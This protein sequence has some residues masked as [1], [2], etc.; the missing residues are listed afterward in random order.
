MNVTKD[1]TLPKTIAD[2]SPEQI[3]K[4]IILTQDVEYD[5][6][7]ALMDKLNFRVEVLAIFSNW[8][9]DEIRQ[10]DYR[11]VNELFA[12]CI[13][14]LSE[15]ADG[16]PQ[17][18]LELD[19]NTYVFDKEFS[20]FTTG[21]MI[22]LKLIEDIHNDPYEALSILYIEEGMTYNEL[23]DKK[24]VKNPTNKRKEV[25]RKSFPGDEFIKVLAF[26]LT[27]YE[28]RKNATFALQMARSQATM[29]MIREELKQSIQTLSGTT[30]QQ[31]S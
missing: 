28:Q 29:E 24:H 5:K 7:N 22:D 8:S 14:F 12:K 16:E 17:D 3:S 2:C 9:K 23:D 19:G 10:L 30:G 31:T 18:N 25:F 15:W 6:L 20:H 4:W 13:D 11:D 21:Q 27:K 1:I 26:F